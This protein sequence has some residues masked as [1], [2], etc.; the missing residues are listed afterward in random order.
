MTKVQEK[1]NRLCKENNIPVSQL[2]KALGFSNGFI[3]QERK[4][5]FPSDR[6]YKIAKY[7]GVDVG[8]LL[9]DES[10]IIYLMS[11]DEDDVMQNELQMVKTSS[12]IRALLNACKGLSETQLD[13]ITQI[14]RQ[15]RR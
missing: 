1:I 14:V 13:Q 12:G 4:T 5:A 10:E 9:T 15:I 6:L 2:E 8:S 7:F 11:E 3:N